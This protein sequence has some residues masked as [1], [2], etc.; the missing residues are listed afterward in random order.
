MYMSTCMSIHIYLYIYSS[1]GHNDTLLN[2]TGD[3]PWHTILKMT[4]I[5]TGDPREVQHPLKTCVWPWKDSFKK[6]RFEAGD[7]AMTMPTVSQHV[8]EQ[9]KH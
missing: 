7:Y 8:L 4:T 6:E 3:N 5:P 9:P 2:P 1:I